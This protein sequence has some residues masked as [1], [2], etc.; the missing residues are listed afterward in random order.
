MLIGW[1]LVDHELRRVIR[2]KLK[3]ITLILL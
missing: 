1:R 3:F 2:L